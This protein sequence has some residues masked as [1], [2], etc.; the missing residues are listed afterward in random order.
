MYT[1]AIV[2][3]PGKN[4]EEGLSTATLGKP[5]YQRALVQHKE[6]IAALES[7]GLDVLVLPPENNYPDATF[8]EDVAL[9]AGDMAILTRPGAA[10]R[11]GE[12]SAIKPVIEQIFTKTAEVR[13]PGTI[14]GGDI[15]KVES[16]FYIGISDR[17]NIEGAQQVI[18]LL[19]NGGFSS[20]TV[21]LEKM[22]HLKTGLA[23]LE[24]N[25]LVASGEMKQKKQFQ[26]YNMLIVD[27][28][29]SYAAN[30]IWI[31]GTVLIPKDHPKTKYQIEK[32]GYA[33]IEVNVSEFQKIDGGLSCLSLRF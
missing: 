24:N 23:Y 31:N 6:Y 17:T 5:D 33:V 28:N 7:C 2:R 4:L 15:L 20:S 11:R 29:E 30:C 9:I 12:I 18:R 22:L 25:N 13:A 16:H 3:T 19:K 14:E 1:R 27:P 10:S 21:K 26:S 8:V 32:A